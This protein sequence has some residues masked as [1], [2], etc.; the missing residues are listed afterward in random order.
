MSDAESD[1][2]PSP[3]RGA[4]WS[5]ELEQL[6]ELA[7]R[8]QDRIDAQHWQFGLKVAAASWAV[9][10]LLLIARP[11]SGAWQGTVIAAA[12]GATLWVLYRSWRARVRAEQRVMNRAVLQLHE[13]LPALER[14][15]QPLAQQSL[16]LR[17]SRLAAVEVPEP[18]A[19]RE[20]V[21]PA[22]DAAMSAQPSGSSR[23]THPA[24]RND[25]IAGERVPRPSQFTV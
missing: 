2:S 1:A 5:P 22:R 14:S 9:P 7:E 24:D 10:N 15:L 16:R 23:E 21:T 12:L 13:L 6:L 8:Q 25:P 19:A 17:L 20:G 4:T 11:L 3:Y 18:A